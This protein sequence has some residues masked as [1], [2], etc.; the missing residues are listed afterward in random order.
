MARTLLP[1]AAILVVGVWLAR[2]AAPP[3]RRTPQAAPEE[4][5]YLVRFGLTDTGGGPWEGCLKV[6]GGQASGLQGWQFAQPDRVLPDHCWQCS[7]RRET[8][9]HAPWERSLE[10]TKRQEKL[11][12]KG[13]LIRLRG[14]DTARIEISTPRG[15]FSFTPAD[16]AGGPKTFLDGAAD[17]QSSPLIAPLTETDAAED[18]PS[19]M[20][21]SDGALWLAYQSY[22]NGGDRVYA[23]R[24]NEAPEPLTP[25]GADVFKTAI[26]EDGAGRLWVIWAQQVDSNWDL[27]GRAREGRKWL[28][29]ER[30][31]RAP[32]PD[33]FHSVAGDGRGRL[34]LAWQS[35]RAGQSDI[36]LRV[37]EGG[38]WGPEIRA[39]DDPAN[40]WEP[41][42]AA[43]ATGEAAIVWD[44]YANG[45]YDVVLRRWRDGRLQSL[46]PVAA[47][48]AFEARAAAL[49]DPQGRLWL[50]W[51]EGDPGWGK[52]YV[53]GVERAGMGLLMRRQVRIACLDGDQ[54]RSLPGRLEEALPE[55]ER[56]VFHQAR[57][58]FDGGGNLWALFHYRANTPVV[59]NGG[60]RFRVIWRLGASSFQNGRWTPLA[61]FP[62]G[63]G[64]MD[65]PIAALTDRQGRLRVFWSSDGRLFPDAFPR[66]QDLYSAVVK[67]GP[68]VRQPA[69]LT[70]ASVPQPDSDHWGSSVHPKEAADVARLRQYRAKAGGKT[71]QI[72]RGDMHRH[73]DVSWD[74]NRDGSLLDC[75]RYALD[76]AALDFVGV[77][78]HQAGE[79]ESSWW[80]GQQAVDLFTIAGRFAPLYGYERSRGYPS[81]HRNVMFARR[82]VAVVPI[83]EAERRNQ[84]GVGR[85]FQNLRA[86]AGV[87]MPHTSATGAGTDWSESDPQVETLVEIYQGY[88]HNYEHEGAPR[89]TTK[90]SRPAG[91]V[92]KAWEKG[93]KI[94]VQAS[95]DHVSTHA[96]Y[97]LVYAAEPTA[98]GILEALRARRTYA[99]TDNILIDF[100]LHDRMMGESFE[101]TQP[102]RL[103]ARLEGT[104]PIRKVELI[105]NNTYLHTRAGQG[106]VMELSYLDPAPPPGE[107]YYYLRVEQQDGQLAWSSPIWVKYVP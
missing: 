38:K 100:R 73:T 69:A 82:G 93:W 45:N 2:P 79:T 92:W 9:W 90:G 3:Q 8:Y 42:V 91:F 72:L 65:F 17:A 26:A 64:R 62:A 47:T 102:P 29:A 20:E 68:K 21:A 84:E 6:E 28:P 13:I 4:S 67:P 7:T 27:Y 11:T 57:L 51:D 105:R 78:D 103:W 56:Q 88:R 66:R 12:R 61:E 104:A 33:I 50:A 63:Y 74:G 34:Y 19:A 99:A 54:M 31:T 18:Y 44:S 86:N 97:S 36:Y 10:P 15:S 96:S 75:Y 89:S 24:H 46:K 80:M 55:E 16:L 60:R 1:V 37:Q 25:P 107:N 52:D 95:S 98:A 30:L 14:P 5:S 94:G 77:A 48:A 70:A 23:R 76:A 43:S 106:P 59:D 32:G 53:L 49:Y 58:A 87:V 22:E 85:L 39:S 101:A 41:A 35:F 71:Y 83:S 40:D 81:G